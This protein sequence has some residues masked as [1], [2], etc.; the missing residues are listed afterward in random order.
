MSVWVGDKGGKSYVCQG[1]RQRGQVLCLSGLE[2]KGVSLMYV[3][4]GDKGGKSYVCQ[5]WRQR[6]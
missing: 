4:V 3:R 2:T 5:G 1:W 6:G